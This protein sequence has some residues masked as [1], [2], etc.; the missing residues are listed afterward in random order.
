[1]T[2]QNASDTTQ[3]SAN[4]RKSFLPIILI[5]VLIIGTVGYVKYQEAQRERCRDNIMYT[6]DELKRYKAVRGSYPANWEE[7]DKF[8]GTLGGFCLVGTEVFHQNGTPL[9][10]T[11]N[12]NGSVNV[13]CSVHHTYFTTPP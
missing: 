6:I 3:Q 1:M 7:Y 12:E 13:F 8:T 5:V 9:L 4:R 10:L 2:E 11:H